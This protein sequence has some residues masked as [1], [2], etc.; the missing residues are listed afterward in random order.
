MKFSFVSVTQYA[1]VIISQQKHN[2]MCFY[3]FIY[4]LFMSTKIMI[5][6]TKVCY[7]RAESYDFF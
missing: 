3:L 1:N 4:L 5:F 7:F 2:P 6:I